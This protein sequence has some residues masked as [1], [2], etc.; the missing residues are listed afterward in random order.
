MPASGESLTPFLPPPSSTSRGTPSP[1]LLAP[2]DQGHQRG[3]LHRLRRL[4]N[5]HHVKLA[6]ACGEIVRAGG[7][8]SA[9]KCGLTEVRGCGEDDV[10]GQQWTSLTTG[11]WGHGA[12]GEA[13]ERGPEGAEAPGNGHAKCQA[14]AQVLG[15]CTDPQLHTWGPQYNEGH[16]TGSI[17]PVPV[18]N[19]HLIR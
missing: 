18:V 9:W 16:P 15:P 19:L 12:R 7:K 5:H 3:G 8:R 2:H 10:N 14:R 1:H 4:V 11:K 13:W 6:A 17:T